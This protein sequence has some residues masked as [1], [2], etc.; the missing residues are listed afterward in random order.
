MVN[1]FD[2]L[3][4]KKHRVPSEGQFMLSIHANNSKSNPRSFDQKRSESMAMLSPLPIFD[5]SE[6][7]M[8]AG[9]IKRHNSHINT[10]AFSPNGDYIASGDQDGFIVVSSGPIIFINNLI[11]CSDFFQGLHYHE[12]E[13]RVDFGNQRGWYSKPQVA[14]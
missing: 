9:R 4:G 12:I 2:T 13:A 11:Q 1:W 5:P 3:A 10:V 7:W 6:K 14:P 8:E